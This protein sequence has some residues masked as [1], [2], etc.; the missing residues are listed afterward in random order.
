MFLFGYLWDFC[1]VIYGKFIRERI[2]ICYR[3]LVLDTIDAIMEYVTHTMS[4][5]IYDNEE[6]E[7][8]NL[9][10]PIRF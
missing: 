10:V 3:L 2:L 6:L 4:P 7:K 5:Y 1:S 9:N 8:L